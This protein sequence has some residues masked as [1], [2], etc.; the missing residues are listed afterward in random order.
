M[1]QSFA[2]LEMTL[3]DDKIEVLRLLVQQIFVDLSKSTRLI[4][5]PLW[6]IRSRAE[7]NATKRL[8]K[9]MKTR[10]AK[11]EAALK[12]LMVMMLLLLISSRP[13]VKARPTS[14]KGQVHPKEVPRNRI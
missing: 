11:A 4:E 2:R 1:T 8:K 7:Q 13:N 10:Q 6:T 5:N 14:T 12:E 3:K 9:P